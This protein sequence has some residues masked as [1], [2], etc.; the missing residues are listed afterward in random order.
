MRASA[1]VPIVA[2]VFKYTVTVSVTL[3]RTA[4]VLIVSSFAFEIAL[5][6]VRPPTKLADKTVTS[7]KES[8][9]AEVPLAEPH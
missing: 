7:L 1:G 5:I 8:T 2:N 4:D 3:M 9:L 6:S